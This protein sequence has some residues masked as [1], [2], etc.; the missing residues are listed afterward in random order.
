MVG[1]TRSRDNADVG[2]PRWGVGLRRPA[3]A[4]ARIRPSAH[5][6]GGHSI[7]SRRFLQWLYGDMSVGGGAAFAAHGAEAPLTAKAIMRQSSRAF[8]RTPPSQQ[9]PSAASARVH[10]LVVL[11]SLS[12]GGL[13]LAAAGTVTRK[14]GF[15]KLATKCIRGSG[16]PAN[17]LSSQSS[18]LAHQRQL[19]M[20]FPLD[21]VDVACMNALSSRAVIE[22]SFGF[23]FKPE[24]ARLAESAASVKNRSPPK[25]VST[26]RRGVRLAPQVTHVALEIGLQ[27]AS[28][29]VDALPTERPCQAQAEVPLWPCSN[30]GRGEWFCRS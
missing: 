4:D 17:G 13:S 14:S 26:N 19:A 7:H 15:A 2:G 6:D 20:A 18:E 5:L 10:R 27:P 29:Q 21:P 28:G 30:M 8:L 9:L 3:S 16:N 22:K 23:L 25:S 11:G 1:S 24:A 12:V